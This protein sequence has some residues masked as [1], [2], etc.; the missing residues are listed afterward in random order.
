MLTD[1]EGSHLRE[2]YGE[3][4]KIITDSFGA[5]DF[6]GYPVELYAVS[7]ESELFEKFNSAATVGTL[8]KK[9]FE[10]GEEVLVFIP[11]Y[12]DNGKGKETAEGFGWERVSSSGIDTT[13]YEEY[14]HIYDKDGSLSV[15]SKITVGAQTRYVGGIKYDYKIIT[16]TAT[17]LGHRSD[18][19]C[20]LNVENFSYE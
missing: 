19:I 15:G 5:P 14:R 8:D 7:S 18:K 16:D 1:E 3:D 2:L 9:A 11:L 17:K 4:L 13:F 12:K 10:A 6:E 20:I